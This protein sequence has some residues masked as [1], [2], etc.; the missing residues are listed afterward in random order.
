MA[1]VRKTGIGFGAL[2]DLD[3]RQVLGSRLVLDDLKHPRLEIVGV[4]LPGRADESGEAGGHV[5]AAR[6]DVGD[7]HSRAESQ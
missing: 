5:A 1:F 2:N 7:D 3:V 4:H 6:P